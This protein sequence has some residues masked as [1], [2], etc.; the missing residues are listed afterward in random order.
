MENNLTITSKSIGKTFRIK[1]VQDKN[2]LID[3]LVYI[4]LELYKQ[5]CRVYKRTGRKFVDYSESRA[6]Y[7]GPT[8]LDVLRF[9]QYR[10]E[11]IKERK[12]ITCKVSLD[13][14]RK[15][16]CKIEFGT[17]KQFLEEVKAMGESAGDLQKDIKENYGFCQMKGTRKKKRI[18]FLEYKGLEMNLW[19]GVK[20]TELEKESPLDLDFI[21]NVI[22]HETVHL[23]DNIE[24]YY[25]RDLAIRIAGPILKKVLKEFFVFKY[26][27]I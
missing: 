22:I 27:G 26:T 10:V 20:T 24:K 23:M 19:V 11:E 4:T 9:Y 1:D 5:V 25:S 12:P 17:H 2:P 21:F 18:P 14:E 13:E 7:I 3:R 16:L 8:L 15:I 6:Y